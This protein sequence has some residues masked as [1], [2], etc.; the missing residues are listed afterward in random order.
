MRA[1]VGPRLPRGAALPL[2]QAAGLAWA[3]IGAGGGG[4]GDTIGSI[5][6][7][8]ATR[9]CRGD[10]RHDD[11]ADGRV[12]E[13]TF[14]RAARRTRAE[15][16]PLV[17]A[18][19]EIAIAVTDFEVAAH[20]N[21]RGLDAS[22]LWGGGFA[23]KDN[24]DLK[25]EVYP[26]G[27][28][29]EMKNANNRKLTCVRAGT[30]RIRV[31]DEATIHNFHLRGPRVNRTTS[32]PWRSEQIGLCSSGR[33]PTRS[34]ATRMRGSLDASR[35]RVRRLSDLGEASAALACPAVRAKRDR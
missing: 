30:Y 4:V 18:R 20:A 16:W 19:C 22:R 24:V 11:G 31:E 35:W 34:S 33:A 3:T 32:I 28:K 7:A 14:G 17:F 12:V 9:R 15:R 2:F 25:G 1:R 10:V 13:P 29:I 23:T 26:K 5:L 8:V 6:R 27:F 21:R